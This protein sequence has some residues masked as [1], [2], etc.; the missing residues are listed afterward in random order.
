MTTD[1]RQ[2]VVS[3]PARIAG[4]GM[5]APP[6]VLTNADFERMV[7]TTDEWIVKRTGIRRRHVVS[8]G[9]YTSDLA[10]AAVDDLLAH[11]PDVNIETID[12]IVVGSTTRDYEYPSLS[13]MLQAHYKLPLTV[14]AFDISTA[15]AAFAYGLNL[16]AGLI[17]TGQANRVLIV[18]ADALTR[19]V[20]YTDRSTCVL[21]GDGAGAALLEYS[22]HPAIFGMDAGAD[23]NGG[24]FLYRTAMRTE[25]NGIEDPSRLLRQEGQAV[26]RWVMENVPEFTYRVVAR[27]G[28]ALEDIDWFVPHSANLRMIE[29][30]CKRLPFPIERTLL[31][32][33]EYGNT[34]AVSIPLALVPAVRDGRVQPGQRILLMGFGGGLV[35]A[36]SV[37]VWT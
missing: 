35:T 7:D 34:S 14:G 22:R 37:L 1:T 16:G 18:T 15:C 31:S 25:I 12:Y 21:F 4:L 5:Y 9:Q 30:L 8:E 33:E 2:R 36:G 17:G 13:A 10:I 29:A 3:A 19:S 6:R 24:K 26:Y 28:L 27:A 32:V 23:G 20:D 11:H